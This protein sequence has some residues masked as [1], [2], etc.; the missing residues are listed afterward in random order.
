[1]FEK[2]VAEIVIDRFGGLNPCARALGK[3]LSTIQGWKDSGT[4]HSRNWPLI[5]AAALKEGWL[6]LTARWLGAALADQEVRLAHSSPP[7]ADDKS[8]KCGAA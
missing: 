6:D 4:I 3:P 5:E 1:M 2:S 7:T 8:T